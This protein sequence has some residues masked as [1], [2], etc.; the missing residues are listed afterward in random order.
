VPGEHLL[1]GGGQQH[2]QQALAAGVLV[3]ADHVMVELRLLDRDRQ[4]VAGLVG[5]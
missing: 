1:L 3:L 2:P 5:E 4:V